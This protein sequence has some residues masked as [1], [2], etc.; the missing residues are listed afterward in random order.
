MKNDATYTLIQARQKNIAASAITYPFRY[1]DDDWTDLG[2]LANQQYPDQ[3]PLLR[4]WAQKFIAGKNT[5]TLSL[6]KDLSA[7]VSSRVSY[8]RREDE[9]TQSPVQTP[10]S[11][12]R[13][14]C[15]CGPNNLSTVRRLG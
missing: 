1:S 14:K 13:W 3:N 12:W 11:T 2:S 5:D 10:R 8:E 7:G 4:S 15:L 9:G 6:L